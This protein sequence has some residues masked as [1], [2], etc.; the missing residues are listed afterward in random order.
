MDWELKYGSGKFFLT[1]VF[2]PMKKKDMGTWRVV[3]EKNDYYS[4]A[5]IYGFFQFPFIDFQKPY[6]INNLC[7]A[8][9]PSVKS[10]CLYLYPFKNENTLKN[11]DDGQGE[12]K[13][14]DSFPTATVAFGGTQISSVEIF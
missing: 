10:I 1:Q 9:Y 5:N 7:K 6:M 2:Y 12:S 14:C 4:Q 11:K 8:I 3:V 13:S